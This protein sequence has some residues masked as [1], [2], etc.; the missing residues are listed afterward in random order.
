MT[1][2]FLSPI[3]TSEPK[4]KGEKR[5]CSNFYR[6]SQEQHESLCEELRMCAGTIDI[7]HEHTLTLGNGLDCPAGLV[8]RKLTA[9]WDA[10]ADLEKCSAMEPQSVSEMIQYADTVQAKD[11]TQ[12]FC[13]K[14]FHNKLYDSLLEKIAIVELLADYAFEKSAHGEP[15]TNTGCTLE[16]LGRD[17]Q[18]LCE[19]VDTVRTE[20]RTEFCPPKSHCS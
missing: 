8:S 10:F 13:L 9:L 19:Q 18:K 2:Q 11:N 20:F 14:E 12:P 1:K 7:I 15:L 4:G 3:I 6:L 5:E 17:M 16:M